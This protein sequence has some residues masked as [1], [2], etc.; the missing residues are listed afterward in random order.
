MSNASGLRKLPNKLNL[1]GFGASKKQEV[2]FRDNQSQ[3]I[4]GNVWFSFELVHY[5]KS[6]I[7]VF[8]KIFTSSAKFSFPVED[9]ALG[10]N[11]VKF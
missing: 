10:N 3:N 4:L 6:L 8:Q 9:S 11:S 7:S 5:E 2:L 1:K